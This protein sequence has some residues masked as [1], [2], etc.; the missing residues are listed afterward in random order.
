MKKTI[1]LLSVI[2]GACAEINYRVAESGD[3]TKTSYPIE[4]SDDNDFYLLSVFPAEKK[5]YS[6]RVCRDYTSGK[7]FMDGDLYNGN[8]SGMV[9]TG[10]SGISSLLNVLRLGL[11]TTREVY[12]YCPPPPVPPQPPRKSDCDCSEKKED[13]VKDPVADP[14]KVPEETKAETV[15]TPE[16][17]PEKK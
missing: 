17:E 1:L 4:I 14:I 9:T 7:Y 8:P 11:W 3:F 6:N 16:A 12:A 13:K 10:Y 5:N 2:F 15:E